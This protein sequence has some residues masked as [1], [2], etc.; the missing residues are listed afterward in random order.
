MK[1]T[2][3]LFVVCLVFSIYDL[4][5]SNTVMAQGL[6]CPPGYGLQAQ[7][8]EAIQ[9][10][11]FE[12]VI[13]NSDEE[14]NSRFFYIRDFCTD[15]G[16]EVL[17]SSLSVSTGFGLESTLYAIYVLCKI[18]SST[19]ADPDPEPTPDPVSDGVFSD[20]RDAGVVQA[21]NAN[22]IE[23]VR[24]TRTCQGG[25]NCQGATTRTVTRSCSP[26]QGMCPINAGT[27][28]KIINNPL[29][30]PGTPEFSAGTAIENLCP[31]LGA[32]QG[33]LSAAQRDLFQRC[34]DVIREGNNGL[35]ATGVRNMSSEE[36]TSQSI[37]MRR[38]NMGQ[39]SNIASRLAALRPALSQTSQDISK[40]DPF[41]R[42]RRRVLANAPRKTNSV[43]DRDEAVYDTND[44]YTAETSPEQ[45]FYQALR[46]GQTH[47]LPGLAGN[48]PTL[49][50]NKEDG[51]GIEIGGAAGDSEGTLP[52]EGGRLGVY[53]SGLG[54]TAEKD[55]TLISS[56]FDY[57]SYNLTVGADYLLDSQTVVGAAIGYGTSDTDFSN[58]GGDLETDTTTLSLYATRMLKDNWFLDGV[59]G[60]G[61]SDYTNTRNLNYTASGV[62]VN[63]SAIGEGSGD[64]LLLSLGV[65]KTYSR[66][67]D[68]DISARVN[69]LD[70][71]ID[72]FA[73]RIQGGS[74]P[75]FGLALEIDKQEIKS[76]TSDI[77]LQVSKAFSRSFGVLVPS[78]SLSWI[79]EFEDGEDSL[80]AR[81]LNDPFSIDF[82]QSGINAAGGGIP[83]IFEVPLDDTDSNYGRV[84]LGLNA[85]FP[86]GMTVFFNVNKTIGLDNIDQEYFTLGIRKNF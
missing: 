73:E 78:A 69:Y 1:K 50:H 24:Q 67:F 83:T 38:L 26:G 57:D 52:E 56:A 68:F 44:N 72:R 62:T 11:Y 32:S 86:H 8:A 21:C 25:N 3:K 46:R 49:E 37:N 4:S 45:L 16:G 81:F 17:A 33:S 34:G 76:V 9:C 47:P 80:R 18:S 42:D 2:I 29:I 55:E 14:A 58:N 15:D 75:G 30:Q 28:G 31:Q 82:S 61:D 74:S 70:A 40:I 10:E 59:I 6:S 79:H 64:Q 22:C 20:W 65:G 43:F 7:S 66:G 48:T 39:L 77:N 19:T 85:L 36:L 5:V 60:Y 12:E 63:Q 51:Y 23:S 84:G 27:Q 54:S 13:L 53:V 35:Q 71:T 41:E